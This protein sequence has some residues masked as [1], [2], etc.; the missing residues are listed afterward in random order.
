MAADV[1]EANSTFGHEAS[2]ESNGGAEQL[3]SLVDGQ[4][5]FHDWA[6]RWREV[7]GSATV[8]SS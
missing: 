1:D 5:L 7:W 8:G 6:L 3:G 4:Q 2:R